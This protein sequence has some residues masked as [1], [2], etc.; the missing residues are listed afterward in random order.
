MRIGNRFSLR[1]NQ[2]LL[3]DNSG[4][5]ELPQSF[6]PSSYAD[7]SL[8]RW[9][10]NILRHGEMYDDLLIAHADAVR[11][12]VSLDLRLLGVAKSTICAEPVGK[13]FY[14]IRSYNYHS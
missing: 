2:L 14:L 3:G 1:I 11:E 4:T 7:S 8:W 13:F 9:V 10:R 5:E 12:N 6:V